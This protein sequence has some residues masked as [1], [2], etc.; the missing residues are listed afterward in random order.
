MEAFPLIT[1][2]IN[3][4]YFIRADRPLAANALSAGC[5]MHATTN[6]NISPVII[7]GGPKGSGP[8][9]ALSGPTGNFLPLFSRLD[10]PDFYFF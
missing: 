4:V 10:V 1:I 5:Q 6:Q 2:K 7:E 3:C 9:G 8:R